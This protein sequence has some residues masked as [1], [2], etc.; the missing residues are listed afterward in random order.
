MGQYA[1]LLERLEA[2]APLEPAAYAYLHSLREARDPQ[3]R[4]LWLEKTVM[5]ANTKEFRDGSDRR[6]QALCDQVD[7]LARALLQQIK[8]NLC[9]ETPQQKQAWL[10]QFNAPS[11]GKPEW[12]FYEGDCVR[13]GLLFCQLGSAGLN[14]GRIW[15]ALC[16]SEG[17]ALNVWLPLSEHQGRRVRQ[18][19]AEAQLAF[20]DAPT[21]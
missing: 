17:V 20:G 10:R 14:P 7:A 18:A 1:Q 12:G 2:F 13:I 9:A 5:A 6:A 8:M 11:L 21:T 4:H 19:Q 15:N 3:T 16:N